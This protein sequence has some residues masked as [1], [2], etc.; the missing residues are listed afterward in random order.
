MRAGRRNRRI[1]DVPV[2]IRVIPEKEKPPA[3]PVDFYLDMVPKAGLARRYERREHR[4]NRRG[5]GKG[6]RAEKRFARRPA[7]RVREKHSV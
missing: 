4:R 6:N 2:M 3:L 7:L 5:Q 1:Y